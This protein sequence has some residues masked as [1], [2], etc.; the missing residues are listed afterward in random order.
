MNLKLNK[1]LIMKLKK[2]R[3][4][5]KC[6]SCKSKINKSDFYGKKNISIGNPN[7]ETIERKDNGSVVF[8]MH[9]IR[10]QVPICQNCV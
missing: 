10:Y 7:K 5:Y 3:K 6:Y 1:E 2:A 8:V 4:E 9:G